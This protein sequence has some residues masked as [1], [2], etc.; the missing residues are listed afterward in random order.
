MQRPQSTG[1]FRESSASTALVEVSAHEVA[2]RYDVI[3]AREGVVI[4][5]D[6][7]LRELGRSHLDLRELGSTGQDSRWNGLAR[8]DYNSQWQAPSSFDLIDKMRRGDGAV[9]ATL[10][11]MKTPITSARWFMQPASRDKGDVEVAEKYWKMLTLNQEGY[12]QQFLQELLLFLDFG[13]YTF[14]KVW[15]RESDG[16]VRLKYFAPRHPRDHYEWRFDSHGV[17]DG[18]YWNRTEVTLDPYFLRYPDKMLHFVF[19]GEGGNPEGV[20]VLRSAYKHWYYKENLYKIDAIQKERHGIG[21]PVIKLPINFN[22]T[23]KSLAQQMGRNLRTN[24]KAHVV[25]PPGFEIM[26][27]RMEGNPVDA[28]ES[29]K[30]HNDMI[31]MNILA[32]FLTG[33][34]GMKEEAGM[35]LF[36]R[37]LRYIAEACAEIISYNAIAQMVRWNEGPD[38]EPPTLKV[39]RVGDTVDWRTLSFAVRNLVGAK[40]ITP[41]DR[42]EEFFRDEMDL[43]QWD[44]DSAREVATPQA[45]GARIGLPR[46]SRPEGMRQAQ[47]PG[48]SGVGDDNSGG[49]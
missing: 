41:D 13:F 18:A 39:R 7:Q 25:L 28:L 48:G 46:Q 9:R 45:P 14:E 17:M 26:M 34:A 33:Q 23:D 44:P 8:T 1:R 43:S 42:L 32:M 3:G 10:R 40:I 2:S 15:V 20:S 5:A 22:D 19:D 29:A 31:A 24:E 16:T 37:S 30:H 21:I 38:I 12:W 11:L 4:V 49:N 36:L 47:T 27:L 6:R 35:N